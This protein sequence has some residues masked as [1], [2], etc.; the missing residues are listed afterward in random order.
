[1]KRRDVITNTLLGSVGM[2]IS[3]STPNHSFRKTLDQN[4][5]GSIKHSACKW[6]YPNIPLEQFT[7]IAKDIN[8][9]SIEL[10]DPEQWEIVLSKGIQCAISNGSKLGITKGFNNKVYHS[11]LYEEYESLIPKAAD[12]GIEQI[13][14]FSGNRGNISDKEG[15]ENCAIGLDK[16][17]KICEKYNV[18]LV[19]ELLNSKIDHKDYMCDK[20]SWGVELV[21]KIGSPNFKLL[22]DIYHMQIM[23]GNIIDTILKISPYI[24]HYHTGG[25]PGRNEINDSQEL[26]Y[27]AIVKAI[28]STG[29]EGYISQEFIPLRKDPIVSLVE[30]MIICN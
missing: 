19:M 5:G 7:E 30:G 18:R 10:L 11:K 12:K 8:L 2:F 6:C 24:S 1:M 15:L 4:P 14:C 20:T 21:E 26:N 27:E 9:S 17:V 13:I 29:Y 3:S 22:Y 25:V 16:L 23:E 28:K